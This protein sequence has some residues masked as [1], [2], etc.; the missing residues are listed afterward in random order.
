M[1]DH[2]IFSH[3]LCIQFN[4][5]YYV[6]FISKLIDTKLYRKCYIF[7]LLYGL[8]A[9]V[10]SSECALNRTITHQNH[11]SNLNNCVLSISLYV[12]VDSINCNFILN[13]YHAYD[14]KYRFSKKEISEYFSEVWKINISIHFFIIFK[15]ICVGTLCSRPTP[16]CQ[17]L[18]IFN[19]NIN[20]TADEYKMYKRK[21]IIYFVYRR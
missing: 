13:P 4:I 18:I 5:C 14:S 15:S 8:S 17:S 10:S 16:F 3:L 2:Y 12:T 21:H 20:R 9:L 1:F 6:M 7:P 11:N 19:Y